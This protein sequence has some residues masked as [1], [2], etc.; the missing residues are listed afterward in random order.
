MLLPVSSFQVELNIDSFIAALDLGLRKMFRGDPGHLKTTVMDEPVSGSEVRKRYLVLYDGV[1]GGTGYLKELMRDKNR[2]LE[3]FDQAYTALKTCSCQRDADKD[4][5]YQCLLAYRGR[6][7]RENTSRQAALQLLEMILNNRESLK[8]TKKLDTIKINRLLESELEGR[9]IEALRRTMEGESPRTVTHHVV[10]GKQ[11][12]YLKSDLGNY[13][14]EPQVSLGPAEGV[15]VLCIAD[16]VFYPERPLDGELPVVVFT[17]GYE[18]HADPKANMRLAKD[19]AQRF[20]IM[21]SGRYRV[22][23]LTWDDVV[24][25]FENRTAPYKAE[26]LTPGPKHGSL[27]RAMDGENSAFWRELTKAS[28]FGALLGLLGKGRNLNWAR[29]AEAFAV[30]LLEQNPSAQGHLRISKQQKHADGSPLL[31]AEGE[32]EAESVKE[33]DFGRLRLRVQLHDDHAHKDEATWKRTWR[34][35]LRLGNLLQFLPGLEYVCSSGVAEGAYELIFETPKV[36]D[37]IVRDAATQALLEEVVPELR[38]LCGALL[39]EGKPMPEGGYEFTDEQGE[40]VATAELA[41]PEFKLVV[42]QPDEEPG[43]GRFEAQN[44]VV[45]TTSEVLAVPDVLRSR[46]ADEGL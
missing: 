43:R 22:W 17:D 38:D 3:V 8:R 44:W 2:L 14:I 12:F 29:Q 32:V 20:A 6:H 15:A 45:L 19:T 5:C 7:D 26:A 27:L 46:L 13:Q 40:I 1:P 35:F 36:K 11:G 24:E 18:Y 42:L 30:S 16:F 33:R 9:F 39:S 34:E 31:E 23:S 4:G 10:N 25:R 28:S 37:S 41:W 21:R